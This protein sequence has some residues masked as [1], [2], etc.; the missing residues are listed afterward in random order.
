M[1]KVKVVLKETLQERGMSINELSLK[2]DVRRAALSQLAGGKRENINF[3]HLAK[4]AEALN[5]SDINK[6]ITLVKVEENE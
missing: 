2:S 6:I 3:E 5:T 4:I 1:Y